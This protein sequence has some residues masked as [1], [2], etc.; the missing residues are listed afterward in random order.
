M[1]NVCCGNDESKK[2][3]ALDDLHTDH[4]SLLSINQFGLGNSNGQEQAHS[5]ANSSALQAASVHLSPGQQK[6][7]NERQQALQMEQ[8][9]LEII[10]Q[11]AGR[12]M[13]STSK[14]NLPYYNDQGFASALAQHL[15]Q[16]TSFPAHVNT[17]LPAYPK[18]E[19]VYARLSQGA[20]QRSYPIMDERMLDQAAESYLDSAL[21][22]KERLFAGVEPMVENL[23]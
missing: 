4:E 11:A 23:L 19:A 2:A 15:E 1:G 21:V 7:E 10:V 17:P 14:G 6:Q 5:T 9:R 18:E 20:D 3:P 16:T 22:T 13:V 12:S 8:A